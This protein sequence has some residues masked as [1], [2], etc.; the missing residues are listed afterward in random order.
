MQKNTYD[1]IFFVCKSR[2]IR[3]TILFNMQMRSVPHSLA[4]NSCKIAKFYL[5]Y[6]WF[7]CQRSGEEESWEL[8]KK[9]RF[10]VCG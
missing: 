10:Y 3:S 8:I 7:K 6:V 5:L 1:E 2:K 4:T 9:S